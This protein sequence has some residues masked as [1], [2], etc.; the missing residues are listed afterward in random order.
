[1]CFKGYNEKKTMREKWIKENFE[2]EKTKTESKICKS[3]FWYGT[4][5]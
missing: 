4:S 2:W 5:I 1:M 3:N